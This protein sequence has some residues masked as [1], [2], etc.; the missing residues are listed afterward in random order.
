MLRL[1]PS[2]LSK[3]SRVRRGLTLP[4]RSFTS[5]SPLYSTP[6]AATTS[7]SATVIAE[8]VAEVPVLTNHPTDLVCWLLDNVHTFFDIPYW[9]AIVGTTIVIRTMMIPLAIKQASNAQ[10]MKA[11]NPDLKK[12][13]A[14]AH[15][16][17]SE[18]QRYYSE[19]QQLFKHY[20]INPTRMFMTPLVQAPIFISFFFALK[21]MGDYFPQFAQGGYGWFL[22]LTATDPTYI[23]PALNALSFLAILQVGGEDLDKN[24]QLKFFLRCISVISIPAVAYMPQVI[25]YL[26]MISNNHR[27]ARFVY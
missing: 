18:Q 2:H 12:L 25:I 16:N 11:I 17:P 4:I 26:I 9:G 27:H 24:P 15:Q 3:I 10:R 20:D 22:D 1:I 5:S 14:L 13:Q 7:E 19:I 23:L 8:K 6:D 21:K